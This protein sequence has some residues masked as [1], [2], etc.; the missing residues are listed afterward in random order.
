MQQQAKAYV[1]CHLHTLPEQPLKLIYYS[2]TSTRQSLH[3]LSCK[4]HC[5]CQTPGA[6]LAQVALV[7]PATLGCTTR[8]LMR[9]C[10]QSRWHSQ[11]CKRCPSG[12]PVTKLCVIVLLHTTNSMWLAVTHSPLYSKLKTRP[13]PG[14][15]KKKQVGKHSC[16]PALLNHTE[17]CSMC[18]NIHKHSWCFLSSPAA[19]AYEMLSDDATT[20]P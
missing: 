1:A 10:C 9:V 7:E 14:L 20:E 17:R 11:S 2:K 6:E 16:Q 4:A 3:R 18:S 15:T 12:Q 13:G 8:F 5:C 19:H